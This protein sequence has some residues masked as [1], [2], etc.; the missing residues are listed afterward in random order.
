M[1]VYQP[2]VGVRLESL[3]GTIFVNGPLATV[4]HFELFT[5]WNVFCS[6]LTGFS[7]IISMDMTVVESFANFEHRT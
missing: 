1:S 7:D 2:V 3:N 4:L 5:Q 6:F